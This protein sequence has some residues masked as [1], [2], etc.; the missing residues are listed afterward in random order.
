MPGRA[1]SVAGALTDSLS[2]F[3]RRLSTCSTPWPSCAMTSSFRLWKR[4]AR[5]VGEP[6]DLRRSLGGGGGDCG[7][8]VP[9]A[10]PR[11]TGSARQ[12]SLAGRSLGVA[13]AKSHSETAR[14]EFVG[15]RRPFSDL[16]EDVL[17]ARNRYPACLA[18]KQ[19]G[20]LA[21]A[22]KPNLVS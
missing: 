21:A 12:C 4:S 22:A 8:L 20:P 16:A 3:H 17:P 5:C 10:W 13:M 6:W 1:F 2:R 14:L 7:T 11:G 18:P 19:A 15:S 9:G